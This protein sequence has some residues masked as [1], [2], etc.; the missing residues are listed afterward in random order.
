MRHATTTST[1]S[2]A[3]LSR[4]AHIEGGENG[5]GDL[6]GDLLLRLL[7]GGAQVRGADDLGPA[8]QRVVGR[9]RL[10]G[11]DVQ[12]RAG[13]LLGGDEGRC[14]LMRTRLKV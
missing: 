2:I 9:G 4:T 6:V 7:G 14:L 11:E 13:D 10:L 3:S 12:R 8:H 1:P 5:L